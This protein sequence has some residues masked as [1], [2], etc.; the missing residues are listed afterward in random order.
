L[1]AKDQIIALD[2]AR[3]DKETFESLIAAKRPGDTVRILVFRFDNVRTFDIKLAG[4]VDGP[5][6]I[7]SAPNASEQQRRIRRGWLGG[8]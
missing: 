8:L 6:R 1:N 5:Y 3:V 7:V 4:R 2:G